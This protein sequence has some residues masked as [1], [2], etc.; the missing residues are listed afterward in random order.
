[1]GGAA[2]IRGRVVGAV[3]VGIKN[4]MQFQQPLAPISQSWL[5]RVEVQGLQAQMGVQVL[6]QVF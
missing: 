4:T 5:E 2:P 6:L 1:M 3:Q